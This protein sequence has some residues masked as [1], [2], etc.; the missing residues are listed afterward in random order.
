MMRWGLF[1]VALLV[2][3]IVQT[4]VLRSLGGSPCDLLLTLALVSG[5]I[6]PPREA[7]LAAWLTGL[8]QDMG[9]GGF[10]SPLGLYA[11][12]LGLAGWLLTHL[13]E[14]VNRH[15]WWARWVIAFAAAVPSQILVRV[16][17]RFLQGEVLSW[18]QII[19]Q[20]LVSSAAA[21]LLAAIVAGVPAAYR[22]Y[23]Q[24]RTALRW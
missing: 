7:R 23:R 10:R 4:T 24:R 8:A 12:S 13:R 5:L 21:G 20:A 9:T 11:L 18:W 22:R 17:L 2:T 14:Q 16:H 19:G 3:F 1:A 6:A 15:L